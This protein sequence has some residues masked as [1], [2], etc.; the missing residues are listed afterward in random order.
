MGSAKEKLGAG[1]NRI[2]GKGEVILILSKVDRR[3]I[4][5]MATTKPQGGKGIS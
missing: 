1:E 2:K 3:L 4:E 5:K